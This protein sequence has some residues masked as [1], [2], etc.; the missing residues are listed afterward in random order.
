[1]NILM[2]IL[3]AF[4]Q[5][6]PPDRAHALPVM[7]DQSV[8]WLRANHYW[9]AEGPVNV[10]VES[11]LTA[12]GQAG[13]IVQDRDGFKARTGVEHSRDR[14]DVTECPSP[15]HCMIRDGGIHVRLQSV[16]APGDSVLEGVVGVT[17]T[18]HRGEMSGLCT[19]LLRIEAEADDRGAWTARK[20]SLIRG[21]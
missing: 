21:C 10:D 13:V 2:L 15:K 20:V 17:V 9:T 14:Q 19:V 3:M 11:Y 7:V 18:T 16:E 8:S 12:L 6:P 1:M 4:V 5:T